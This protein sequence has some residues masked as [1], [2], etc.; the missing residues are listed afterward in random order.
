MFL[1]GKNSVYERLKVNSRSIRKIFLQDNFKDSDIEPLLKEKKVAT[2]YLPENKLYK[3]K[4]GQNLQGIVAEVDYFAYADF[5]MLLTASQDK[6][7]VLILLDRIYDPQNLG[8]IIRTAACF[9]NFAVVIPK[10]KACPVTEVVLHVAQGAEN[11]VPVALVS[12]L[13]N[14]IIAAKKSGCWILGAV[15][16][17]QAQDITTVSLPFPLALVMGSEGQGV[18]Y[19]VDKYLDIK[20]RIPMKG[21]AISFNVTIACAIFCYEIGK[22][23]G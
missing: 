1:Y 6:K 16:Q 2:V 17:D 15:T 8:A 11:Y 22:Q 7:T 14:A 5:D 3:I 19:G 13:S 18:R 9:G 20:A 21:A 23:R 4:P 12:N 10:H